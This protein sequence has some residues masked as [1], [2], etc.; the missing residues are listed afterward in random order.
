MAI[1]HIPDNH[2]KN[3]TTIIDTAT[4]GKVSNQVHSGRLYPRKAD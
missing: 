4:V 1:A 3:L 2:K